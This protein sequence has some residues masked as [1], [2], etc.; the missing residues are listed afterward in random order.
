MIV[1]NC[2]LLGY[3]AAS[4][5]NF[6]YSPHNPEELGSQLLRGGRMK[7]HSDSVE[8]MLSRWSHI[9]ATFSFAFP[10]KLHNCK[11]HTAACCTTFFIYCNYNVKGN[12]HYNLHY[13]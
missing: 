6:H 9:G 8:I 3:Y 2:I 7:S 5:G 4:R 11:D 13:M 10:S 1:K 12:I